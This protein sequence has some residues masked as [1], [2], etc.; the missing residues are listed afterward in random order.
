MWECSPP[1]PGGSPGDSYEAPRHLSLCPSTAYSDRSFIYPQNA[2]P[3]ARGGQI[4]D[5]RLVWVCSCHYREKH[6]NKLS[7]TLNVA[8]PDVVLH[9]LITSNNGPG[10]EFEGYIGKQDLDKLDPESWR[11]VLKTLLEGTNLALGN[12]GFNASGGA[13]HPPYYFDF[14][15]VKGQI[16]NAH[17]FQCDDFAFIVMTLPMVELLS[18]LSYT[19]GQSP[20]VRELL[21]IGVEPMNE[22][23]LHHALF[24]LQFDFLLAHEYTHHVHG[25]CP[26][27]TSGALTVWTEFLRGEENA[28]LE[29]QAHELDAD[30]YSAY[31]L[32]ANLLQDENRYASVLQAMGHAEKRSADSD[33]LLF[34]VFFIVVLN[35][36][37]AF[38]RK[39]TEVSGLYKLVN[40]PPPI[41][42]NSIIRVAQMFAGQNGPVAETWFHPSRFTGLFRIA[43]MN[44]PGTGKQT[45]DS[46][47]ALLKTLEGEK[48]VREL[49]EAFEAARKGRPRA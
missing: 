28:D 25:H 11:N 8:Y 6:G 38:W 27:Q 16:T 2:V 19:L 15:E 9:H 18:H 23:L 31:L 43:A 14:L 37:C 45:W 41:R 49:S 44:I 48:Y 40:P 3:R 35:V 36:F 34:T 21:G 17:A 46:Q 29:K 5:L 10:Q 42:I 1:A 26:P 4:P 22:N 13:D 30:G 47:I 32:L 39:R 24:Q 33:E 7:Q 20:S 12:E